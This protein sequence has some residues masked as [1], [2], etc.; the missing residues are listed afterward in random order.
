MKNN[1]LW[2]II[3]AIGLLFTL[4]G[5]FCVSCLHAYELKARK[6]TIIY[7]SPDDLEEFN[8]N[9]YLSRSLG[10]LLKSRRVVT[11][12]DEVRAKVDILVDK[13]GSVLDM[14][15][16]NLHFTLRIYPSTKGVHDVYMKSYG[17]KVN[18][19]AFYSMSR[20]TMYLAVNKV[21]LRVFAHEVG[22]VVVDHYF[23]V[24]PPYKIHEVM[25]QYAEKHITD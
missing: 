12:E 5:T 19:I 25:A 1:S 4:S 21:N 13:V 22:H 7:D 10:N 17:R 6:A 18:Y 9:I 23:K 2:F 16:K 11:M 8:Y 14:N 3:P 20:K 15:P 24:R